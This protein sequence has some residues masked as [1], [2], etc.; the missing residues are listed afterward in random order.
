MRTILTKASLCASILLTLL[1]LTADNALGQFDPNTLYR[2]IAK[3]SG[4]CLSVAGG[5][6]FTDNG[7]G[8]IQWDCI[9]TEDNQKWQILPVGF[10]FYK[11]IAKHSGRSLEVRGGVGALANGEHVQQWDYWGGD[12]QKWWFNPVGD[13]FYQI[14][15]AHSRRSLDI[16]GGPDATSNGPYAQQWDYW[17]GDNQK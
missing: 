16:N 1:F 9:E 8:V 3:H 15:A 5:N 12:N 11:I 14:V 2:I 17:G 7:V 6:R 10:G 13:G 4:R